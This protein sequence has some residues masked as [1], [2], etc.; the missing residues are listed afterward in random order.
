MT[1]QPDEEL[2]EACPMCAGT[3]KVRDY[4]MSPSSSGASTFFTIDIGNLGKY[5]FAAHCGT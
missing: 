1:E 5:D 2:Q 3:G 4:K